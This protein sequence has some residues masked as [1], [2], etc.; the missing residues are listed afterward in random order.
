[1]T[2]PKVGD[3]MKV[4]ESGL[5]K[6]ILRDVDETREWMKNR[7]S[8]ALANKTMTEHAA[9]RRYINNGDYLS[10]DL[11]SMVRGPMSLER[12]IV[13]QKKKDLWLAA[14]FTLLDSTLLVAGGCVSKIDVGFAG[15]GRPLFE[16]IEKG[17]IET[18][19]WSNWTLALRHLAGAM[20]VPFLPTRALLATDTFKRSGAKVVEDPFTKKKVCLVPAVNPDVAII[21]VNQCDIYGN[22][23]IFGPSIAPLETAMASKNVILSTEEIIDTKEIRKN[24]GK[25]TIPYYLV[26]AVVKAPF[27]AHP[28]TVPGRYS[29]DAENLDRFFSAGSIEELQEYLEEFVYGMSSHSDYIQYIG[30]EKLKKLTE[31]ETIKEGYYE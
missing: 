31:L 1:M 3:G 23:R 19:D 24:P 26:N 15:L 16:A 10:Y 5:G 30:Q 20:G 11:S 9:V 28:G 22:A 18:I 2:S 4:L 25:T 12:E 6:A 8:R 29:Y 13:R 14:K 7:K 17:I 21:H 27:G